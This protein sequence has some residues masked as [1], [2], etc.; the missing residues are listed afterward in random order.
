MYSK[1]FPAW[2]KFQDARNTPAKYRFRHPH[3]YY[4]AEEGCGQEYK[5][6]LLLEDL[7]SSGFSTSPQGFKQGLRWNSAKLVVEEMARFHAVGM[8]FKE[9]Q[10][11]K[12]YS[13]PEY[14]WLY[15]HSKVCRQKNETLTHPQLSV[16]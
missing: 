8:A 7:S 13:G 14:E 1:M 16:L 15:T 2:S 5:M 12:H 4:A 6:V 9:A 3:C 11:M 10:G